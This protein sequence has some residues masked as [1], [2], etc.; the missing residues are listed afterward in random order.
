[1]SIGSRNLSQEFPRIAILLASY[2]GGQF[3]QAQLDSLLNQSFENWRLVVSDDGSSDNTREIVSDF[4]KQ[5]PERSVS[6][7]DGPKLGATKNFLSMLPQVQEG[8]AFAFC[9]QDDV[10]LPNRLMLGVSA[11]TNI[12]DSPALHVTRTTICDLRLKPLKPAPLYSRP[13]SFRNALVQ[14]CTPANT[15]LVNAAGASALKRTMPFAYKANVISHDWWS[16]LVISGIGGEVIR[17]PAQTV[18]YRQHPKNVMGR[19]DTL[20]AAFARLR[21]LGRGDYG[22]WLHNN[23]QALS[24]VRGNLTEKNREL[25]DH[26]TQALAM[27]GPLAFARLRDLAVYRQTRFG[28]AAL[29]SAAALGKLRVTDRPNGS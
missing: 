3:L 8:E 10:W 23:V 4:A 18:L 14:A 9:D 1:M 20:L 15:M 17:D 12:H 13:A 2:N 29:L 7:I 19:N 28:T 22:R 27:P 26:F 11:L 16:Y 21:G 6:L 24:T 25:L 5:N